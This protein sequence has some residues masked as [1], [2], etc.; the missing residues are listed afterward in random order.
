MLNIGQCADV[1]SQS[2]PTLCNEWTAAHQASLSLT[3]F[4]SLHKLMPI[5]SV[6]PSNYLILCH[7]LLLLPSIFPSTRVFSNESAPCIR[8][9]RYWS[10]SF[11]ISP[12]NEN[13]Q[14][15][16]PLDLAGLI[17]LVSKGLSRVFS[18]TT[19]LAAGSRLISQSTDRRY[20]YYSANFPG[21][22]IHLH[23]FRS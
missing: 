15:W 6:M 21:I 20:D 7:P 12:S 4:Q 1:Q 16:F 5:V 10:L 8:W 22:S 18:S 19:V 9:P 13:I 3:I 2:C 14:G 23:T 11:N 17:A